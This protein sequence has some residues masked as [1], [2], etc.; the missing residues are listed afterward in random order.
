M[1][2]EQKIAGNGSK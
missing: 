2:K 1:H